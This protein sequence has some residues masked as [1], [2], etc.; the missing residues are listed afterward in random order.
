MGRACGLAEHLQQ[1]QQRTGGARVRRAA[2]MPDGQL[3]CCLHALS[4]HLCHPSLPPV[5]VEDE[6]VDQGAEG[7]AVP[8]AWS[9][10]QW[11]VWDGQGESLWAWLSGGSRV[12]GAQVERVFG[13]PQACQMAS[14]SMPCLVT[15]VTVLCPLLQR[16][17]GPWT[18]RCATCRVSGAVCRGGHGMVMGKACGLEE[19]Q[20]QPGQQCTG[21]ALP[22]RA[23]QQP[24]HAVLCCQAILLCRPAAVEEGAV[25]HP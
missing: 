18:R 6:A 15:R 8:G 22:A 20:L 25:K 11:W 5:A 4:C 14:C 17:R 1:G 24:Q 19:E 13:V 21:G 23:D 16:R 2:G 3:R 12:G 10:L 9:G 7:A